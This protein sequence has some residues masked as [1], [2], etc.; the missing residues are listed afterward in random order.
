MVEVS[1]LALAALELVA[2]GIRKAQAQGRDQ[3]ATGRGWAFDR[4]QR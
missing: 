2:A 3:A 4:H 1:A